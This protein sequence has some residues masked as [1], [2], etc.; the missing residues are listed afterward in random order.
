ME[1]G[2]GTDYKQTYS[3]ESSLIVNMRRPLYVTD[4][5]VEVC[6]LDII[7]YADV[8]RVVMF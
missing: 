8:I 3:T 1:W 7:E 2:E 5:V 6:V 4:K